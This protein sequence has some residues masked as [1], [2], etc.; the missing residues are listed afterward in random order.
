MSFKSEVISLLLPYAKNI[1]EKY[2]LL[3]SI[4]ISQAILETGWLKY[5]KGIIYLVSNGLENLVVNM[6]NFKRMNG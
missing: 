1:Q 4:T 3:P 6:K 5:C 2:S